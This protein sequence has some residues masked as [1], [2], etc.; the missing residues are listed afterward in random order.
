[1]D[2]DIDIAKLLRLYLRRLDKEINIYY[3]PDCQ[4]AV[5]N[6]TKITREHGP[7][8]LCILDLHLGSSSGVECISQLRTAGTKKIVVLTAYTRSELIEQARSAGVSEVLFKSKG[9]EWVASQ[10]LGIINPH[11]STS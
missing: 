4:H 6:V 3:S 5:D 1:M 8:D 2:D 11:S 9:F 7:I 10:I